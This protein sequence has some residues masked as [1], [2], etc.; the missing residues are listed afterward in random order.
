MPMPITEK[1]IQRQINNWN[2]FREFLR[3]PAAED[4][5]PT[6]PIITISRLA[7]SGG[8]TLAHALADRLGMTVHDQSLV[9]KI[10]QDR[11]L[12]DAMIAELDESEMNQARLWVRGVLN[13][14]IFMKDQYHM[15]LVKVVTGLAARGNV[16]FL[17][18]GADLILGTNATLR[19]RLVA[20]HSTR[21]ERI[22]QR[23][24]LSKPK[25]RALMEETDRRRHEYIRK[26]FRCE[27]GRP[28]DFDLV[29]NT[30]RIR[31][32]CQVELVLLA[33]LGQQAGG[34]GLE[35][36]PAAAQGQTAGG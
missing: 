16:V 25:A 1:L 4:S 12:E 11:K 28:E 13:Q 7:G 20:S 36:R 22:R 17:G 2:R 9:E 33:L 8:R 6:G 5:K 3:E 23:S 18:R 10:A 32:E 35:S 15:A 14:K 21:L 34:M 29:L 19:I 31:P 30:D 26:V 24:G 27:P